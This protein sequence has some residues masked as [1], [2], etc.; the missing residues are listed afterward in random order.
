MMIFV[1]S[2]F[3][4]YNAFGFITIQ[5]SHTTLCHEGAKV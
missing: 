2:L 1:L 3:F 5:V 4:F